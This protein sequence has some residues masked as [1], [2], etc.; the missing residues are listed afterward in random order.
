MRGRGR[1][2][3]VSSSHDH[4]LIVFL[5]WFP[6][7]C[8]P[9]KKD[10]QVPRPSLYTCCMSSPSPFT[11]HMSNIS[12]GSMNRGKLFSP[13]IISSLISSFCR[14]CTFCSH[15]SMNFHHNHHNTCSAQFG[16]SFSPSLYA[17]PQ[18]YLVFPPL[19]LLLTSLQENQPLSL[20]Q[21]DPSDDCRNLC[22]PTFCLEKNPL[23]MTLY[24][25]PPALKSSSQSS[26]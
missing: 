4:H 15:C 18:H 14:F 20:L 19:L 26:S 17:F 1:E 16:P 12:S 7:S 8:C 9:K 6:S 21:Q 13:H 2:K 22:L 3:Q 5:F 24:P 25:L 10:P 11:S 23:L